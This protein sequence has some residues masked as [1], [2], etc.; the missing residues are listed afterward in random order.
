MRSLSEKSGSE[1][2]LDL[3][4]TGKKSQSQGASVTVKE[5]NSWSSPLLSLMLSSFN[6]RAGCV[7]Q[8]RE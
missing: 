2:K 4:S 3:E 7:E 5:G 8:E 6:P 1:K